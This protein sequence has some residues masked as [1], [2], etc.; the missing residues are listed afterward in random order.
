MVTAALCKNIVN[1]PLD[2]IPDSVLH[3]AKRSFLNWVGVAVGACRH[4][5][6]DMVLKVADC[7]GGPSQATVLGRTRKLDMQFAAL[8]NGMSS[9]I[10]DFDDTLLDTVLHPSAPM[11]PALLAWCEHHDLPGKLLLQSFVM[12]VEVEQRVSQAIYPSHYDRGWHITGTA[13]T[14]GAAAGVGVLMGLDETRMAYAI[15]LASTQSTG[16]REMFG[17]MTKP[18]HPGKA[19]ANGLLAA[20]LA[21]EGFTSS[22]Q[23]LEAKRGYGHVLSEAPNF[24]II[25]AEWGGQWKLTSNTYKPFACGIVTHPAIEAGIRLNQRGL[26][27]TDIRSIVLEVHPLVLELTGKTEP[28]DS[29]QAKFSVYHCTAAGIL[30]GACG[31]RQFALD[32]VLSDQVIALRRKISAVI[33]PRLHEDQAVLRAELVNGTVV[34]EVIEHAIGSV[35]NPVSDQ[36]LEDKFR[37]LTADQFSK[38]KQ[39]EVIA[40][41]WQMEKASTRSVIE[42]IQK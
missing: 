22:L 20:M 42:A 14:F 7:L 19:A 28:A 17:T 40:L 41:I 2:Q 12:G 36:G 34:E 24:S 39:D 8:V 29:L 4:P 37:T 32:R 33:N 26:T 6:V 3:E 1:Y 31:E 15:G 11:T 27:G 21:R 5:S 23:S 25:S 16:L 35:A 18:F 38:T 10:F 30:D 13:G 9:H